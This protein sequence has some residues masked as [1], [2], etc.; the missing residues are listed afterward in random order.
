MGL[1]DYAN[2]QFLG[3]DYTKQHHMLHYI[4]GYCYD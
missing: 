2:Q 3:R 4:Y 1:W